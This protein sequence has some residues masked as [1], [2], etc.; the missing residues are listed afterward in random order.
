V[1]CS[2]AP[3]D[4]DVFHPGKTHLPTQVGKK[5]KSEVIPPV[6]WQATQSAAILQPDMHQNLG[7]DRFYNVN[8]FVTVDGDQSSKGSHVILRH[9]NQL[10]V[11]KVIEILAPHS[12]PHMASFIVI[13]RLEFMPELHLQLCVPCI[14][15]AIP[16]YKIVVPPK[17]RPSLVI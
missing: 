2:R 6:E 17:V 1:V 15:F 13:S 9:D 4:S 14:K 16:E 11:G 5:G 10:S 12:Q 3:N 8:S 7:T